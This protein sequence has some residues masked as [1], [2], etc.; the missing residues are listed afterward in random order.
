MWLKGLKGKNF[1]R[2]VGFDLRFTPGVNVLCGPSGIGKSCIRR[3]IGFVFFN[4]PSSD[5]IIRRRG[6]K[7]TSVTAIM[8]D[9]IEVERVKSASINRYIVRIPG[10]EEKVWD[11][12]GAKI[13][14]EVQEILKVRLIEIDKVKLNLNISEQIS[15]PFLT[16]VAGST[17]L[18]LF[19]KLTGN[20][21]L[22]VLVGDLN[23]EIKRS[24]RSKATEEEQVQKIGPQLELV[25]GM[26]AVKTKLFAVLEKAYKEIKADYLT[27]LK[28]TEVNNTLIANEEAQKVA[29]DARSGLKI[30]S[31]EVL[32]DLKDRVDALGT[33]K[34]LAAKLALNEEKTKTAQVSLS[35]IKIPIVDLEQLKKDVAVRDSLLQILEKF[36]VNAVRIVETERNL[37]VLKMP[38]IDLVQLKVDTD[39]LIRLKNAAT[40]IDRNESN[41]K[42]VTKRWNELNSQ[43]HEL[44][45]KYKALLS[46]GTICT[47]CGSVLIGEHS[48]RVKL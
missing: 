9:D 6:T 8:D 47:H 33:Y 36:T 3:A 14:E 24:Q 37:K 30:I 48:H 20:E 21:L 38:V 7:Q 15:M 43:L 35:S 10:Q 5:N 18:K 42:E 41:V 1:Q 25:K 12:I 34:T 19:N 45:I 29:E 11:S 26:I 40:D 44:E 4:E 16:D 31:D 13:P 32:T 23:L 46:K 2:H 22:D 28:Y 27:Y 39:E 17:R